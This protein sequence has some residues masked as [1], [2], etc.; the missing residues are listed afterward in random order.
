MSSIDPSSLADLVVDFLN[1]GSPAALTSLCTS[2][3]EVFATIA[4]EILDPFA[5]RDPARLTEFVDAYRLAFPDIQFALAGV[6]AAASAVTARWTA[7]GTHRGALGYIQPSGEAVSISGTCVLRLSGGRVNEI[8]LA[9]DVYDILLQTGG[10][11]ADPAQSKGT[12]RQINGAA[13]DSLRRAIVGRST[14]V[15][16]PIDEDTVLHANV[17]FY[18]SSEFDRKEFEVDGRGKFRALLAFLREQF[19]SV[20][21]ALDDGLSQGRTT[22]FRGRARVIRAGERYCY[23][24]RCG[25]RASG[26]RIGESWVELQVPPTLREVFE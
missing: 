13:M 1:G 19:S 25:F 10:L 5:K 15:A 11:C 12:A 4:E 2:G 3:V 20:E 14:D 26:S 24:F 21:P 18:A 16:A 8:R 17:G 6:E 23:M 7:R 22:T 9:A